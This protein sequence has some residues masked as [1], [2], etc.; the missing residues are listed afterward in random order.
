[1]RDLVS[2]T[3][4]VDSSALIAQL[5]ALAEPNRLRI[6]QVLMQGVHCNCEIVALLDL[7]PNLISHHVRV[8]R[9]AGLVEV[10][11]DE[12]DGR[13]IYYELNKEALD[14]LLRTL[15]ASFDPALIKDRQPAF[16]P[17]SC[18]TRFE[19]SRKAA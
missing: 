13:W 8:L 5:K 10:E 17:R 14:A 4:P 9:E 7:A 15:G 3:S 2:E 16:G 1:M 19:E 6:V 11:R 12:V 18:P